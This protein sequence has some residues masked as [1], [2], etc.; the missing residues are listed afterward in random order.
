MEKYSR[1]LN[2]VVEYWKEQVDGLGLKVKF[3]ETKAVA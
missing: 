2:D 1:D 3:L